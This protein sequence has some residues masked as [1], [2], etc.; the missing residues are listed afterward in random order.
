[1]PACLK[2]RENSFDSMIQKGPPNTMFN[3]SLP[4]LTQD[5]TLLM[6]TIGIEH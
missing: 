4:E 2:L 6:L 5:P 3:W 1:M